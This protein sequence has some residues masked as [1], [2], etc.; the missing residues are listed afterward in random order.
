MVIL[1]TE[2]ALKEGW[3]NMS[4][5]FISIVIASGFAQ[6]TF[7]VV[8]MV[9]SFLF[10]WDTLFTQ[11][12]CYLYVQCIS[13]IVFHVRNLV[14]VDDSNLQICPTMAYLECHKRMVVWMAPSAVFN[15]Q[16]MAL[17][18]CLL[19]G[20]QGKEGGREMGEEMLKH[21]EVQDLFV[22]LPLSRDLM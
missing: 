14:I 7:L 8:L 3:I 15:I 2:S 10:L 18:K 16:E 4:C 20:G 17:S 6:P 11:L 19:Q 21:L 1:S 12:V 13:F 22:S 5:Q 9:R